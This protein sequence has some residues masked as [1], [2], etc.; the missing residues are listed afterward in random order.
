MQKGT[1]K[2]C[3]EYK[4]LCKKSHVIPKFLYKL[5]TDEKN[6]IVYLDKTKPQF[7]Y[8]SEYEANILCEN[9][10]NITIGKFD[11]YSAKLINGGLPDSVAPRLAK[12]GERDYLIKE[13]D[14]NYNYE[15]FKLFLISLLWRC[16][17]SNR[18][19]FQGFKLD[20]DIEEDLRQRILANLP[21]KPDC[22]P[23]FIS[24]PPLLR[25][26]DGNL[27]SNTFH[28]PTM[29][30]AYVVSGELKM[31][32]FVIQ[33]MHFYFIISRPSNMS[34]EPSVEINKLTMMFNTVEEQG[35][36]TQKIIDLMKNHARRNNS[37]I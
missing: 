11:D 36:L 16:S 34:V 37:I 23:C 27:G 13:N 28:M 29:S 15:S 31:C 9:C 22:Y 1:C 10:D 19:F 18:P 7:K 33:G 20:S 24:L 25:Q 17:I 32:E 4:D 6:M 26:A 14:P 2:L 12:I 30:P 3:L 21:G 8:N 35:E 5:L